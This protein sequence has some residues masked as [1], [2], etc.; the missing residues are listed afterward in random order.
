MKIAML[1]WE[2]M[3]S[4][5]IGG[6]A[7]HVTE[8]S[9]TLRAIG[10]EVHV[11]TRMKE[12]QRRYDV[13]DG[14]HYHRC[15]YPY[16][17]DFLVDMANMAD[18]FYRHLVEVEDGFGEHFDVVH[19]H[20]WMVTPVLTRVKNERSA[21]VVMT[22][23]STE[24][25][26]CGNELFW[27]GQ[28]KRIRDLEWEGTFIAD[29]VICVSESLRKETLWLYSVP[30]EKAVAIYNGVNA[31]RFD[32]PVDGAAVR[33]SCKV[34]D[35]DPFIL[36][37]GR[38]AWQKG[39]DLMLEAVPAVVARFPRAKFV[40][41]GEGDMRPELE[42][43]AA[44]DGM[45]DSVRFIGY[46]SGRDL[47]GL[48]K[49]AD[50]VCVPSRN[51]P[52]G[53]VILEAWS[54]SKAVVA[55]RTGGPAEFVTHTQTGWTVPCESKAIG[56]G[57]CAVLGDPKR[58]T[59]MGLAGRKEALTRFSWEN[60]ASQTEAVYQSI[61][62]PTAAKPV[63]RP[64]PTGQPTVEQI[65]RRAYEIYLKRN[66][67]PGTPE[68]DWRQAEQELRGKPGR[69]ETVAAKPPQPAVSAES[70]IPASGTQFARPSR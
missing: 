5:A 23:H 65:R 41:A 66:G 53:I 24:Y 6:I 46:R 35:D 29:R 22:V 27:H 18:S 7:P 37:A 11:F 16:N 36:F 57:L 3:H 32:I 2:S 59:A 68:S 67:L 58:A 70:R 10:H 39:P 56:D 48:F 52:F 42:A 31:S 19:G 26:R 17:P 60:I 9:Q 40:V 21:S 45:A 69:N 1:A 63:A 34:A 55:T 43:K 20:D 15:A 38:L 64:E 50:L 13:Y 4:V 8:M 28:S 12:G 14:V 47:I 49:S 51:E 54:A 62:R 44:R 61:G 33:R 25:G 30:A